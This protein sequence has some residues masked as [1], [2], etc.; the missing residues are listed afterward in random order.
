MA[1]IMNKYFNS[2]IIPY[3]V[4]NINSNTGQHVNCAYFA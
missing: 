1:T 4:K 3:T 2:K